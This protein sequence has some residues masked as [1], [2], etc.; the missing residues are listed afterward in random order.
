MDIS[1]NN[2]EIYYLMFFVYLFAGTIKGVIGIGLP[3]TGITILTIF[4]TP[5]Q[6]IGLNLLPMFA[7][8][9]FQFIKADNIKKVVCDYWKFSLVM[10]LIFLYLSFQISNYSEKLLRI[11]IALSIILFAFTNV[12]VKQITINSKH[13]SFWQI[14]MGSF[15]GLIGGFT[16]M[17]GVPLTVY[18]LMKNLKPKE[19]IDASGFLISIGCIPLSIGFVKTEIFNDIM[20]WPGVLGVISGLLGFKIG[21]LSRKYISAK[22]FRKL[23][24]TLFFLMGVRMVYVS[25]ISY[26]IL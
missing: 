17:W 23:V 22:L 24:L 13:D 26:N 9:I 25:L 19:F 11:I 16:S 14:F 4:L 1:S 7:T 10:C 2:S 21:E 8:N 3:T 15:S 20:I 6:A 18:L 12:F 5:H